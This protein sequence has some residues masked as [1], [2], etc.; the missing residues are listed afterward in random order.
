MENIKGKLN[1]KRVMLSLIVVLG[2]QKT[3]GDQLL[4]EEMSIEHAP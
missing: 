1:V 4:N 3:I 2:E